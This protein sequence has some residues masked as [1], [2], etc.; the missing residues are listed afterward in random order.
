MGFCWNSGSAL[1]WCVRAL[2]SR[3]CGVVGV[4]GA[5]G[6]RVGILLKFRVGVGVLRPRAGIPTL[7]PQL[8][9]NPDSDPKALLCQNPD[10]DPKALAKLC[11]ARIPTLTPKLSPKALL[12]LGIKQRPARGRVVVRCSRGQGAVVGVRVGILR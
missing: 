1:G 3:L 2:E 8:C 6:V 4:R 9:W 5:V 10:S 12:R 7:T 11:S